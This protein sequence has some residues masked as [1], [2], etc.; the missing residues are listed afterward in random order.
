MSFKVIHVMISIIT[1]YFVALTTYNGVSSAFVEFLSHIKS[2]TN[3]FFS[4]TKSENFLK[5][6]NVSLIL[7]PYIKEQIYSLTPVT[8]TANK[9]QV[10]LKSLYF[11]L[12]II[13]SPC[14][15]FN[16]IAGLNINPSAIKLPK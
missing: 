10:L 1:F 6:S 8:M 12:V 14:F 9:H 4:L 7:T 13:L 3:I 5:S 15:P 11:S 2:S 16:S